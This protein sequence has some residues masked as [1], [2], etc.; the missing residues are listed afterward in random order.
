MCRRPVSPT[1]LDRDKKELSA[2][3]AAL[4]KENERKK[5][6]LDQL[7]QRLEAFVKVGQRRRDL[8]FRKSFFFLPSLLLSW[9]P[10]A[11]TLWFLF[12]VGQD[13][14]NDDAR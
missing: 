6:R 14:P 7:E 11:F 5:A 2:V 8:G 10:D 13:N 1:R 12:I 9:K 3:K 4:V